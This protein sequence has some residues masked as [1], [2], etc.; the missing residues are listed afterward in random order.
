VS[1]YLLCLKKVHEKIYFKEYCLVE[2]SL[3]TLEIEKAKTGSNPTIVETA[4]ILIVES[5]SLAVHLLPLANPSFFG[6]SFF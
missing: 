3:C 6:F 4:D 1:V 2:Q 5:L